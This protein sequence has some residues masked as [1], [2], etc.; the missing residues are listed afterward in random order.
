MQNDPDFQ[1]L[2]VQVLSIAYDSQSEQAAVQLEYGITDVPMLIDE[3]HTVS[4]AYH[5]LQWAM[6][7]GEP[8]HTFVLVNAEGKIAWIQDYGAPQNGSLMYVP[9]GEVTV[10]VRQHL[11]Q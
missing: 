7:T 11:D 8:G 6:A 10:N 4:A 1:A 2:H 5:V 9:V 3:A